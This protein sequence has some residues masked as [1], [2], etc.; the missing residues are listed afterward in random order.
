MNDW[1][2]NRPSADGAAPS[3]RAEAIEAPAA[4]VRRGP[5]RTGARRSGDVLT[6]GLVNNMAEAA[7]EATERQFRGL[8]RRSAGS[9]PYRLHQFLPTA[10]AP[11]GANAPCRH[12]D[13]GDLWDSRLDALIITGME[14]QAAESPRRAALGPAARVVR[15]GR[16][17]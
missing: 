15:L 9:I 8:L 6:I 7:A 16:A 10:A 3:A 2:P 13:V 17:Q 11:T 4:G 1:Y 14:P 5:H 12:F